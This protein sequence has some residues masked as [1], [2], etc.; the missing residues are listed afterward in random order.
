MIPTDMEQF[1]PLQKEFEKIH[2]A[3]ISQTP[4]TVDSAQQALFLQ[5]I[6]RS[7]YLIT[8]HDVE[9]YR[10]ICVND[11]LR[12]FYGLNNQI[13]HGMDHYYY[14]KTMHLSTYYTLIESMAFF[15]N[16]HP[17]YLNLKYKLLESA[18]QWKKTIG[19]SKAIIRDGRGN[20]KVAM[21]VMMPMESEVSASQYEQYLSLTARELDVVELLY[22]G[23]S[24]KEIAGKLFISSDTV[25]THVKN[26]YRKLGV[27][28]ISEL[29]R[30]I[31]QFRV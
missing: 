1:L 25:I 5:V 22:T 27:N 21:T 28:K 14:L 10:P 11:K 31:E 12:K 8:I 30:L 19:S 13:L 26:I 16:D 9:Y 4:L 7:D 23:L 24:K 6:D 17:G 20:P 3:L 29:S 18:G 2:C 15:R